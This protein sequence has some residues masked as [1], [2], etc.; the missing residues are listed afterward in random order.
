VMII[1]QKFLPEPLAVPVFG[2]RNAYQ[3]EM[4]KGG[5]SAQDVDFDGS[6][7]MGVDVVRGKLPQGFKARQIL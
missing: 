2:R 7:R 1:A 4:C 5:V 3:S 6:C